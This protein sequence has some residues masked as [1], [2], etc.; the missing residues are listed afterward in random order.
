MRVL[1]AFRK[2]EAM[3]PIYRN[4]I[5][6]RWIEA[7][8]GRTFENRN[9]ADHR[10]LIGLFPDSGADDVDR[11][12]RAA[13][14]ALSSWRLV[15]APKRGEIIFKIGGILKRRQGEEARAVTRGKGKIMKE[16]PRDM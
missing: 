8:S 9:P 15:P 5:D 10:D 2:I 6:G 4:Y 3:N 11:A 14:R 1:Q 13:R 7:V 16:K 12:V